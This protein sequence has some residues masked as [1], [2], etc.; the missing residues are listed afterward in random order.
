[1]NPGILASNLI[2]CKFPEYLYQFNEEIKCN[3]RN[4]T[5]N[6]K[7]KKEEQLI[8]VFRLIKENQLEDDVWLLINMSRISKRLVELGHLQTVIEQK[9]LHPGLIRTSM[10]TAIDE[11]VQLVAERERGRN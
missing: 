7:Q 11:F 5:M 10:Q 3:Q 9:Y 8:E 6:N 4:Q 1:L 2:T